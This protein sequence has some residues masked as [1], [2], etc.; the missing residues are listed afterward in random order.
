M[1]RHGTHRRA[2]ECCDGHSDV[3]GKAASVTACG[4]QGE[5]VLLNG[6][7]ATFPN[8]IYQ[9]WIQDYNTPT[10]GV[11]INYQSIGSGGGIQQYTDGTIDFGA[12]DAP[13]TEEEMEHLLRK[14]LA[15]DDEINSSLMTRLMRSLSRFAQPSQVT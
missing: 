2:C 6:A 8:I 15:R 7:G 14:N 3:A 11:E 12:T 5:T 1:H 13:M 9:K 10:P 4:G